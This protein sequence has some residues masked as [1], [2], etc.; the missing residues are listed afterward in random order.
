MSKRL[1]KFLEQIE[2]ESGW[3]VV[4]DTDGTQS[5]VE[6][7]NF[8]PA[9][10]EIIIVGYV[11]TINDV[12]NLLLNYYNDF[13]VDEHVKMW[14]NNAGERGVPSVKTLVYDAEKIENMI[15]EL[16][17]LSEDVMV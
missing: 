16:C 14:I 7:Y 17:Q 5:Y 15:Y 11:K 9:G 4:Y 8:S 2:K 10:E 12:I 13:D 3:T 6:F 1:V